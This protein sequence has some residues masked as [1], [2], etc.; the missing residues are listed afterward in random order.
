MFKKVLMEMANW[1]DE[2]SE[3]ERTQIPYYYAKISR[4][5]KVFEK[6]KDKIKTK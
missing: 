3:K 1:E 2:L 4:I 6:Y 5:D